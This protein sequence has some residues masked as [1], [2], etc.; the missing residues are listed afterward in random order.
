M[1]LLKLYLP[2]RI[3]EHLKPTGY[4]TY[5]SFYMEG[6]VSLTDQSEVIPVHCIVE[7]NRKLFEK[8]D[9]ELHDAWQLLQNSDSLQDA[10][11]VIA[12]E[13]ECARL[14]FDFNMV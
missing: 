10:W 12:P 7:E 13:T 5:Q 6:A 8:A 1:S 2:Y 11:A 3:D 9:E 4:D 14:Q